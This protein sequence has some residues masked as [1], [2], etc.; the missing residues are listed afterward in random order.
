MTLLL[1]PAGPFRFGSRSSDAGARD[2]EE[3][4]QT[5]DLDAFWIDRTE[6]TNAQFQQFVG[7]TSYKT[8]AERGCC[9]EDFGHLGGLVY[10]PEPLFVVNATWLLPQGGGAPAAHP[11]CRRCR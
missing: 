1:V 10:S 5:I 3:P 2:D 7:A 9:A 4:Q 6:V 8:D 11:R